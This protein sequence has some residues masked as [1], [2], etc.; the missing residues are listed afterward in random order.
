MK[1][2]LPLAQCWLRPVWS[3]RRP[4]FGS[5]SLGSVFSRQFS[6]PANNDRR[7]LS[8]R[9]LPP[10]TCH[11]VRRAD[12]FTLIELLIVMAVI[13]ILAAITLAG[14]SGAQ[15]KAT[16]DRTR[17]EIAALAN[18][19]ERYKTQNDLYPPPKGENLF[20]SEIDDYMPASPNAVSG[21]NLNDPYGNPYRYRLPGQVNIATF[22]V[23]SQG[24]DTGNT[25]D[26]IGNW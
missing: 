24:Q 18:A 10:V 2:S 21:E 4:I 13:G 15:G 16:R 26:D 9:H 19:I 5:P 11:R 12:A 3:L 6:A 1:R 25:N 8:T 22:D 17:A 20:Y 14:L 23:F 7:N